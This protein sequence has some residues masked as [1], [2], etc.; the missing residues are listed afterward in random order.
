MRPATLVGD[1]L[2]MP[3]GSS[4]QVTAEERAALD[5]GEEI[6]VDP[7]SG[8]YT[9]KIGEPEGLSVATRMMMTSTIGFLR[10]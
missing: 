10:R 1:T 6:V 8:K 9:R 5:A 4:R 2:I 7:R 3:D